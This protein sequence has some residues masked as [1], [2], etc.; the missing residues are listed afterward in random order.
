MFKFGDNE[1]RG[2][3]YRPLSVAICGDIIFISQYNNCILN[4]QLDGKFISK[5][6]THGKGELEFN[7]PFG[8]TIDKSSGNIYVSDWY[9][10]PATS[11][12]LQIDSHRQQDVDRIRLPFAE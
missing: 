6:G 1:G 12:P 9:N 5:I 8:L 4:Y 7:W 11:I 2:K 10:K 3:M